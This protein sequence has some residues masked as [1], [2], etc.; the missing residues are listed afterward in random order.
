[1]LEIVD[2][3]TIDVAIE[4]KPYRVRYLGLDVPAE[5]SSRQEA[6]DFNRFLVQGRTVEL[7]QGS[8]DTDLAGNLIRYVYVDGEMVNKALLTN[9]HAVVGSYPPAFDYQTEFL[10]AEENA[11]NSRRGVWKTY[12]PAQEQQDDVIASTGPSASEF[13]G[14]T[15][16]APS[17]GGGRAPGPCDYSGTTTP[18]IKGNVD[19]HTGELRYHISGGWRPLLRHYRDRR[20]QRRHVFLY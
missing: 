15:L 16:P 2:G 7:A 9:G 3:V 1:M 4:G 17:T 20:G 10:I 5:R 8:V 12:P 19:P 6:L 14:G 18:L 13:S 11:R